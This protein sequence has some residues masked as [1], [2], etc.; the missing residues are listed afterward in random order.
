MTERDKKQQEISEIVLSKVKENKF[1]HH[2][3]IVATGV[4]KS[5]IIIDLIKPLQELLKFKKIIILVD[6]TR[7]RDNNWKED[8]E[9]WGFESIYKDIIEMNTYQTVYKWDKDLSNYLL[10]ADE[11][12]FAFTPGYGKVFETYKNCNIIGMTGYVAD[13]K[14][15]FMNKYLPCLVEYTQKQAQED[16]I[17]N[18]TPITFVKYDL[19]KEKNSLVTYGKGSKTFKT[20]E[21]ISYNYWDKQLRITMGKLTKAKITSDISDIKK[22]ET[23]RKLYGAKRAEILYNSSASVKLTRRLLDYIH[24][25]DETSKAVIFSKRTAQSSLITT[26]TYHGENTKLINDKNFEDFNKGMVRELGLVD[27]INRGVNM[28]NLNFAI[29]EGYN[30]SDTILRQRLGRLMRLDPEDLATIFIMIPY[31][32]RKT[33]DGYKQAATAAVK[34]VNNML[35][36]WNLDSSKIWDYRTIKSDL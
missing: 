2:S 17:L 21:N 23:F 3:I 36:D 15:D 26:T 14:R 5:K 6:N 27:K 1:I 32:M 9:K 12:D 4:G 19:S 24:T 8:F 11:M 16:G 18:S 25:L 7:L 30:S 22:Y 10:I 13:S 29:F 34:W 33:K 28:R 20:S 35:N 31:F